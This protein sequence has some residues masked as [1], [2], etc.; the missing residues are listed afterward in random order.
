MGRNIRTFSRPRNVTSEITQVT[1]QFRSL[2][3]PGERLNQ[4]IIGALAKAVERY[5]IQLHAFVF[6]SQHFH[7]LATFEDAQRMADFMRY[8]TQKLSKEVGLL[9]DWKDSVFPK[10]YHHVELSEELGVDLARLRYILSNSCKENLVPSP[11]DWPGVSSTE[12]LITGEPMKGVWVD[13]TELGRARRCGKKVSEKDFTEEYELRLEPVPS[14]AHLSKESYRKVIL[15]LVREIE[16]ETLARHRVDGTAPIGV[17]AVLARDPHHRQKDPPSSPR[18]WVHAL[19]PEE[20]KKLRAALV[21][22]VAAY[23]VAAERFRKG[24]FDVGFPAGTFPPARPFVSG[25]SVSI[26]NDF[27]KKGQAINLNQPQRTPG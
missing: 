10:R 3:K 1:F 5:P 23:R 24:E 7:I 17:Q 27:R 4:R 8:F 14:L 21:W 6:L 15:G 18:P 13:R 11:R 9:H 19:S 16:E 25:P 26:G 12:A 22:I 20:R 2:L